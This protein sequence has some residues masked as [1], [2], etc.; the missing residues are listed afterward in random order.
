MD[1]D[2]FRWIAPFYDRLFGFLE[3]GRL[4]ELLA[5]RPSDRLLDVGGGTGRVAQ[6]FRATVREVCVVDP[7]RGMLDQARAKTGLR[8]CR[9]RVE[10]LPFADGSF[11]RIIAVDSFHH[12]QDHPQAAVELVRVLA[13]G[14]RLVVEEPNIERWPVK[15]IALAEALAL[16][17]SRFYS[18]S[19][20]ARLFQAAGARVTLYDDDALNYWAVVEK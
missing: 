15:L 16:M 20:L 1:M 10:R 14:G 6:H 19:D 5:P 7:S 11:Q 4:A 2:H 12:F 18:P 3:P 9:G 13:P 17:R 8:A